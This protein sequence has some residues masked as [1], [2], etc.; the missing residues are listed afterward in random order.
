MTLSPSLRGG[1]SYTG[2]ILPLRLSRLGAAGFTDP[3]RSDL[4]KKSPKK[5]VQPS[6]EIRMEIFA[7]QA[8][9]PLSYFHR[10]WTLVPHCSPLPQPQLLL[11]NRTCLGCAAGV[12]EVHGSPRTPPLQCYAPGHPLP[13]LKA[14]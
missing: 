3:F 12:S 4:L 1:S 6:Q 11:R 5:L 10:P 2:A 9:D 14:K 7:G 8:Q 13:L